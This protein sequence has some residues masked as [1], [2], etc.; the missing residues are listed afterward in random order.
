MRLRGWDIV[1]VSKLY[2]INELTGKLDRSEIDV[3]AGRL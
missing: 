1:V 2:N 3:L